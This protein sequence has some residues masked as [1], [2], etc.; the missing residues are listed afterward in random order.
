MCSNVCTIAG[1][2]AGCAH[3]HTHVVER[4]TTHFDLLLLFLLFWCSDDVYYVYYCMLEHQVDVVWYIYVI[5]IVYIMCST[6]IKIT[7]IQYRF[8]MI[9]NFILSLKYNLYKQYVPNATKITTLCV[10]C[11]RT[12]RFLSFHFC[13]TQNTTKHFPLSLVFLLP[14]SRIV[15]FA[16]LCFVVL[17]FAAA[18][19]FSPIML[20]ST[21]GNTL[22]PHVYI[23]LI[24]LQIIG[25]LVC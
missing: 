16:R 6:R 8:E 23:Y 11:V 21:Y 2:A 17:C 4:E 3:T 5:P 1:D 18:I 19:F 12:F 13:N 14:L 7:Y 9:E 22:K 20:L 15:S 24:P 10:W 25:A